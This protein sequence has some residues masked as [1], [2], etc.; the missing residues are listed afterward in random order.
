M[1]DIDAA[2]INV[3]STPELV[4]ALTATEVDPAPDGRRVFETKSPD[5][6]PGDRTFGGMVVAQALHAAMRTVP[7]GLNVHSLHAYFLRPSNPG[8]PSRHHVDAVRDG[9]S[10]T[11][12]EVI[13]E[14]GGKQV[15]RMLCQFHAPE[16]GDEYQLPMADVPPPAALGVPEPGWPFDMLELGHSDQRD[17]G[18]YLS[19]RRFWFRASEPLPDDPIV[20]ACMLAYL[21]D[22]TGASFRPHSLGV[23]GTHTDASLDHT[24][25]FHRPWR[26]DVWTLFD[27]QALIN[28]GGRATLRGTMHG[29]DGT[30]HLSMAQELLIRE[31]DEPIVFDLSVRRRAGSTGAEEGGEANDESS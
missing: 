17:D 5:W 4:E 8:V 29:E 7:P 26:A 6:W 27:L 24:L 18:T 16:E 11:T 28:A 2:E 20:H 31:L 19:T 14:A 23:W 10:F 1:V 13:S 21:S 25:W 9:R 30:L 3:G 15:F 12:R 22:M